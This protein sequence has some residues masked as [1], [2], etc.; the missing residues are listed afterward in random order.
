MLYHNMALG[1]GIFLVKM[2]YQPLKQNNAMGRAIKK[3][4]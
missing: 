2:Y 4:D 3:K 1:M